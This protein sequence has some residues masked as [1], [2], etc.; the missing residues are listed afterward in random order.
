MRWAGAPAACQPLSSS[1]R[2]HKGSPQGRR[3]RSCNPLNVHRYPRSPAGRSPVRTHERRGGTQPAPACRTRPPCARQKPAAPTCSPQVN[4]ADP[5]GRRL[6]ACWPR[7]RR[8]EARDA[9][10]RGRSA[11]SGCGIGELMRRVVVAVRGVGIPDRLVATFPGSRPRQRMPLL[12]PWRAP[13]R[14]LQSNE[15]RSPMPPSEGI[16]TRV[17][18]ATHPSVVASPDDVEELG[19]IVQCAR[20]ATIRRPSRGR[21][22]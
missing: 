2:P 17:S 1:G 12:H 14:R 15:E 9:Q 21:S 4:G 13:R 11:C 16:E 18:R 7:V 10:V 6:W 3:D 5:L 22:R 20:G 8:V 19:G